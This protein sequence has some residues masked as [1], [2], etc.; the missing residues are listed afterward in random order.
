[1]V[2]LEKDAFARHLNAFYKQWEVCTRVRCFPVSPF[3]L[4]S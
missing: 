3:V 2:E 1:M 4:L